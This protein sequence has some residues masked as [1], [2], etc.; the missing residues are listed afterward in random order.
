MSFP[1]KLALYKDGHLFSGLIAENE[2]DLYCSIEMDTGVGWLDADDLLKELEKNGDADTQHC[3]KHPAAK[4]HFAHYFCVRFV[5]LCFQA[6]DILT[7]QISINFGC[8]CRVHRF[9]NSLALYFDQSRS[10]FACS[11]GL[12][13]PFY[14]F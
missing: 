10:Q 11:S 2:D 7:D 3:A 8:Q 6:N 9:R 4:L 12:F 1:V 5:H 13:Q 14:K